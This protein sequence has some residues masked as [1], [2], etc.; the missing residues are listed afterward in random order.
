MRRLLAWEE[1]LRAIC[2]VPT[3]GSRYEAPCSAL[4]AL[5][6]TLP[7]RPAPAPRPRLALHFCSAVQAPVA[8]V[9][10]P[11]TDIF[12]SLNEDKEQEDAVSSDDDMFRWQRPR[13]PL[14][15]WKAKWRGEYE[16]CKD[17]KP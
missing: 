1:E 8:A 12:E 7:P 3:R 10:K 11:N 14:S 6:R 17:R 15:V 4:T 5:P 9:A 13:G 16:G 2:A